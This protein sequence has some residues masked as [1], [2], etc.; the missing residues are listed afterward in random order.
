MLATYSSSRRLILGGCIGNVVEWYNFLLYAYLSVT[1]SQ[2]FFPNFSSQNAL[3]LS[4]LLFAVGF[5]ARPMGAVIFGLLA[6]RRGRKKTL[7][8]AQIFMAIPTFLMC[9]LPTY[10][11]VGVAA[12]IILGVLRFCQ[13]IAIA[14]EQPVALTYL[15]EVAPVHRRGLWVSVIPAATGVGILLGSLS[16]YSIVHWLSP[17]LFDTIG[18]RLC[19]FTGFIATVASAWYRWTLPESEIFTNAIKKGGATAS[20]GTQNVQKSKQIPLTARNYWQQV[21][22]M[23]GLVSMQAFFYQL[24]Y[25]WTPNFL[26]VS[27]HVSLSHSLLI[28]ACSMCVFCSFILFGGYLI[29]QVGRKKVLHVAITGLIFLSCLLYAQM[30]HLS[31]STILIY[32]V[33]I[34]MLFGLFIGAINTAFT[35]IFP[36]KIRA[37]SLSMAFNIPLAIIGGLTPLAMTFVMMNFG[38]TGMAITCAM[39]SIIAL[40]ASFFINDMT[41]KPI[42]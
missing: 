42:D 24:L 17:A 1:I 39:I 18:W 3:L 5:L 30:T 31:L 8:I 35:E 26:N 12:P 38:G 11:Q 37:L 2:L 34:S 16:V 9:F 10:A 7:L 21:I 33:L 22:A 40:T 32:L 20:S 23:V 14:G 28:N 19:F 4:F 27:F 6:D 29:D 15:A 41:G 36:V 25:I 13:G